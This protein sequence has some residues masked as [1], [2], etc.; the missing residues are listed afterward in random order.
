[1][2]DG[3]P[4]VGTVSNQDGIVKGITDLNENFKFIIHGIA[5]GDD[6]D[7]NLVQRISANNY[8]LARKVYEDLDADLQLTG[9]QC[10]AARIGK[11]V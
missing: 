5:F 6:A 3:Q 2:T 4:N 7:F 10:K 9:K 1:M 11:P 8:G